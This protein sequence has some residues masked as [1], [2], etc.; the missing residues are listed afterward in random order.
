MFIPYSYTS[1]ARQVAG[2]LQD[3][4]PPIDRIMSRLHNHLGHEFLRPQKFTAGPPPVPDRRCCSPF[5]SATD[6]AYDNLF[7]KLPCAGLSRSVPIGKE[8]R[9]CLPTRA[10]RSTPAARPNVVNGSVP[11]QQSWFAGPA[12]A[13][14]FLLYGLRTRTLMARFQYPCR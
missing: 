10:A 4:I 13:A 8:S 9:T 12:P 3:P 6:R 7:S 1:L 5:S 2:H 14:S 11:F